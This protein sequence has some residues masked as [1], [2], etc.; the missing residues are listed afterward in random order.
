MRAPL[1]TRQ[2]HSRDASPPCA[3]NSLEFA[4][5]RARRLL[6]RAERERFPICC[7][8]VSHLSSV[9]VRHKHISRTLSFCLI[10]QRHVDHAPSELRQ[11]VVRA[12]HQQRGHLR[13]VLA[14]VPPAAAAAQLAQLAQRPQRRATS[15]P[16]INFIFLSVDHVS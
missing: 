7:Q 9:S 3:T 13:G 10:I 11:R 1:S 15:R 2:R 12:A 14:A 4:E 6:R 8:V 16:G 5:V